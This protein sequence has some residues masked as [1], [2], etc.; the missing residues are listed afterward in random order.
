[1]IDSETIATDV[2]ALR[3]Y[4]DDDPEFQSEPAGY[5]PKSLVRDTQDF[6]ERSG[7]EGSTDTTRRPDHHSGVRHRSEWGGTRG[8]QTGIR[9]RQDFRDSWTE[10][11]IVEGRT[12][13]DENLGTPPSSQQSRLPAALERDQSNQKGFLRRALERIVG[14]SRERPSTSPRP[15]RQPDR[16]R[17]TAQTGF[18]QD[19]RFGR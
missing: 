14:G 7:P 12:L 4:V 11:D 5:E 18:S 15:P 3:E 10:D 13:Y 9:A 8:E 16:Y 1:M 17:G 19:R 6:V 2:N